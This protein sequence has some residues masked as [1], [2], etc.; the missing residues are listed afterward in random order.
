MKYAIIS[1][2]NGNYKVEVESNSLQQVRTNFHQ[3]CAALWNASD[4]TLARIA[5]I[6]QAFNQIDFEEIHHEAQAEE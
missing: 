3:K 5:I 1:V 2:I 4:V 6:D